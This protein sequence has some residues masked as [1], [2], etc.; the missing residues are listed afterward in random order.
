MGSTV[1]VHGSS[2]SLPRLLDNLY[3]S[4]RNVPEAILYGPFVLQQLHEQ[5]PLLR[6]HGKAHQRDDEG[7]H[8][9]TGADHISKIIERH[10]SLNSSFIM[11]QT[12]LYTGNDL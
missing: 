11:D 1:T 5:H 9:P 2:E 8:Q 6:L 3:V 4:M 7:H 10:A 12:W